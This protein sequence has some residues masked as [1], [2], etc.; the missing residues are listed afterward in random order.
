MGQDEMKGRRDQMV[1]GIDFGSCGITFAFGYLDDNKKNVNPGKFK[2]QG[3]NNKVSTEII[4]D[5]KLEEVLC[6][7]NECQNFLDSSQEIKYH[8]FKNIKMNLYKKKYIIEANNSGKEVNIQIIITKILEKVKERAIEEIKSYTL[9]YNE[10]NIHWVITVPAIWDTKSKQIMINSAQNAGLIREDDDFSN[11]FSLEPEAASLYYHFT[12]EGKENDDFDMGE[13]FILCDLGSGTVDIVTQ[14][15]IKVNKEIKFEELYRPVGGE[16]GCNKINEYFMDRVIKQLFEEEC[17]Q[18]TKENICKTKYIKW[19]KF[20][21]AIESFKKTF[22][23]YKQI[24]KFHSINCII[25]KNENLNEEKLKKLI[26]KYNSKFP[27][28]KLKYDED[29]EILF[30]FQIIHDLMF[31]LI[32]KIK[33]YI[34]PILRSK[35]AKGLKTLIFTGGA[36]SN[37]ILFDMMK[38]IEPLNLNYVKSTN[39]EVAIAFGSVLYSHDHFIISPRKA[40]FTFGIKV[41]EVWNEKNHREGGIKAYDSINKIDKCINCFERFITIEQKLRPDKEISH[42]FIMNNKK[43]KIKLYKTDKDNAKFIDEKDEKGNLI[44]TKFADY[45]IDVGDKYDMSNREVEVKMKLGGTFI[46][47]SAIY[48]KTKD[49]AKITC[50]YE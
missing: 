19:Y 4:L 22:N 41:S 37:S 9:N 40:P 26:D 50:L 35:Y 30:P 44:L 29:W 23:D 21:N 38:N 12:R 13:P 45:I 6:F 1:I 28:W 7:G 20:E 43:V 24:G 2:D 32:N 10:K 47:S 16:F 18:K 36:S 34:K 48:K 15:R 46:S 25:F 14:K 31:E 5:D 39:P 33:E 17:F 11:F 27:N 8:H 42:T 49:E 3:I